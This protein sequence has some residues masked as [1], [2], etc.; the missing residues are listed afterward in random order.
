MLTFNTVNKT[1][2]IFWDSEE[3]VDLERWLIPIILMPTSKQV[4]LVRS[5]EKS[6]ADVELALFSVLRSVNQKRAHLPPIKQ[7][8][9]S[10]FNLS[11]SNNAKD[12][13]A[14][15]GMGMFRDMLQEGPPLLLGLN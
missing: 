2:G 10:H 14:K 7:N 13:K 5:R 6:R 1:K 8:G 4:D 9:I 11:F 15:G 12:A 3:K